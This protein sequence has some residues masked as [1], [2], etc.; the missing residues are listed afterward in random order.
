[1]EDI[2]KSE[3]YSQEDQKKLTVLKV[4]LQSET[5]K[6]AVLLEEIKAPKKFSEMPRED[7]MAREVAKRELAMQEKQSIKKSRYEAP[8][9]LELWD[10]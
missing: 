8:K 9:K 4:K 2:K 5:K 7:Q 10:K 3:K 1:M 6:I